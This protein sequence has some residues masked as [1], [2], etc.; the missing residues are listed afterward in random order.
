LGKIER[1]GSIAVRML[2]NVKQKTIG[3]LIQA[4]I[5]AGTL[6]NT[7][8]YYIYARLKQWDTGI[9]LS[10]LVVASMRGTTMA[11]A[12]TKCTSIQWRNSGHHCV[13]GCGCI[14]A[15]T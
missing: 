15:F 12:F 13:P 1:G 4:T 11:I 8:E 6:V 7:D 3:P 10:A 2:Q 9:K 5:A 14:V